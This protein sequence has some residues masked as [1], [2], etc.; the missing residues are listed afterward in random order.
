[1]AQD[2][3]L[4]SSNPAFPEVTASWCTFALLVTPLSPC[5]TFPSSH[6][7]LTE[8]LKSEFTCFTHICW[9]G[10]YHFFSW[11]PMWITAPSGQCRTAFEEELENTSALS[12]QI[13]G[14]LS[15][16]VALEKRGISASRRLFTALVQPGWGFINHPGAPAKSPAPLHAP[17]CQRSRT[18][19]KQHPNPRK[20]IHPCCHPGFLRLWFPTC[21]S[22]SCTP[23]FQLVGRQLLEGLEWQ[24]LGEDMGTSQHFPETQQWDKLPV[25]R[26]SMT[27]M[28]GSAWQYDPWQGW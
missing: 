13:K 15:N 2:K 6:L 18:L 12:E 17:V 21:W 1:M 11:L 20:F 9:D 8:E 23:F 28:Q 22:Q 24:A 7:N 16:A 26:N 5:H 27:W 4:L 19:L 3:A 10:E 25:H 14:E